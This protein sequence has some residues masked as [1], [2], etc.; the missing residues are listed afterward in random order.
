MVACRNKISLLVL[1]KIF[2]SFLTLEEEFRISARPRNILYLRPR[3]FG[4]DGWV[5]ASSIL[6]ILS[7]SQLDF[8]LSRLVKDTGESRE[9][10]GGRGRGFFPLPSLR[11]TLSKIEL[12]ATHS[13]CF[14]RLCLH[15]NPSPTLQEK[16]K[17]NYM[18]FV[19]VFFFTVNVCQGAGKR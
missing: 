14:Y 19:F 16:K 3:F 2:Q 17:R 5:L 4:Q 10:G 11:T 12:G 9:A 18:R 1:K 7:N 8:T 15:P 13:E 6:A